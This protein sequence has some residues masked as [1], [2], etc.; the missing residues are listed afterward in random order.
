[1][2]ETRCKRT[3]DAVLPLENTE[4]GFSTFVTREAAKVCARGDRLLMS[5]DVVH[6]RSCAVTREDRDIISKLHLPWTQ[7]PATA[8][9]S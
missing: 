5:C 8:M 6:S 9:F 7:M 4:I 1:M 2:F 3:C